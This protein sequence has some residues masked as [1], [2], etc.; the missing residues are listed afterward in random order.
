MEPVG[1]SGPHLAQDVM[2]TVRHPGGNLPR[3]PI[4]EEPD[5][6]CHDHKGEQNREKNGKGVACLSVGG[7]QP[8]CLK[9][10]GVHGAQK[11]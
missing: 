9:I 5:D 2:E 10:L 7:S 1:G 4:A 6:G 8:G 11:R 3:V